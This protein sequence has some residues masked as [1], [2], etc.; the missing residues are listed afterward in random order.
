MS[1]HTAFQGPANLTANSHA[2]VLN[3]VIDD[4]NVWAAMFRWQRNFY[5]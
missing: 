1:S 4:Q 5:P 3:G 2:G